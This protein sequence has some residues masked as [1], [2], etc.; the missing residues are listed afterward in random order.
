M[1]EK[2]AGVSS[3]ALERWDGTARTVASATVTAGRIELA[4]GR[5]R[6]RVLRA[7]SLVATMSATEGGEVRYQPALIE[8]SGDGIAT[9]RLSAAGA[10]A[11]F[12]LAPDRHAMEA[13]LLGSGLGD[14]GSGV[15]VRAVSVRPRR[16]RCRTSPACR[17]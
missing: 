5:V 10:T 12:T 6:V 4:D 14:L 13:G 16:C 1:P 7:P 15:W 3:T 2:I 11:E 8:V 17:R 9:K